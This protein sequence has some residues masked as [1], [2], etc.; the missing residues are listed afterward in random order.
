M[1]RYILNKTNNSQRYLVIMTP[2]LI[3]PS[4][5]Y[6]FVERRGIAVLFFPLVVF[7]FV[8]YTIVCFGYRVSYNIYLPCI[9]TVEWKSWTRCF[10]FL[11]SPRYD[12]IY[13]SAR[14]YTRRGHRLSELIESSSIFERVNM[15]NGRQL[16][17]L[18]CSGN[19][20]AGRQIVI[21]SS[22]SNISARA[23]RT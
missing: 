5:I 11:P 1:I 21:Q 20:F 22:N 23:F 19:A 3:Q 13:V 18:F 8:Y 2:P 4:L 6:G 12:Q 17:S 15:C 14:T 10:L 16:H 7:S 9:N